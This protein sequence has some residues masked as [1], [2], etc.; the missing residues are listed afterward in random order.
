MNLNKQIKLASDKIHSEK[1]SKYSKVMIS[2]KMIAS[3]RNCHQ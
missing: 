3:Y 2:E 1:Y